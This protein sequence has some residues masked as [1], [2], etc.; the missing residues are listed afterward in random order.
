VS[1]SKKRER[2][3]P[4]GVFAE[5][6]G[7]Q[8]AGA[9]L[10]HRIAHWQRY[11]ELRR[12][13]GASWIAK[14]YAEWAEETGLSQHQ[15]RRWFPRLRAAG[16]VEYE[17]HF[18]G[19]RC[20]TWARLTPF[21]RGV[22]LYTNG[23]RNAH[24]GVRESTHPGV[25][26]NAHPSYL[27][28]QETS[29][30]TCRDDFSS[31]PHTPSLRLVQGG[32][33]EEKN[34]KRKSFLT[35]DVLA[36]LEESKDESVRED[37]LRAAIEECAARP[38]EKR[39][40]AVWRLA[41]LLAWPGE[42]AF[43]PRGEHAAKL[44]LLARRLG[45]YDVAAPIVAEVLS[46]WGELARFLEERHGLPASRMGRP[47]PGLLLYYVSVVVDW[48]RGDA[49]EKKRPSGTFTPGSENRRRYLERIKAKK[50]RSGGE[51]DDEGG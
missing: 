45:G 30:E 12:G 21:A 13:P 2:L 14:S 33:Q 4:R 11:A 23:R 39:L 50:E 1:E 29:L 3:A 17:Q 51:V 9:A 8:A 28:A 48:A 37:D 38:G 34:V 40:V 49:A 15:V 6:A 16:L 41:W 46:R 42:T 31:R 10:L 18:F 24:P 47:T 36:K 25:R 32:D 27:E 26:E 22:L 43:V 5:L 19:S 44:R 7:T 35:S 20:L